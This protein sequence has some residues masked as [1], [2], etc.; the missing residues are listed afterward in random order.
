M[1]VGARIVDVPGGPFRQPEFVADAA[2]G[3]A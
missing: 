1:R 2:T 3:H